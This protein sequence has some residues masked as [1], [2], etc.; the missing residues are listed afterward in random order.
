MD[1]KSSAN[2]VDPSS[3][4]GLRIIVVDPDTASLMHTATILEEHYYTV[5]T[6][7]L[8]T[9]ALSMIRERENQYDLVIAEFNMLEMDGFTFLKHIL[10]DRNIPVILMSHKANVEIIIRALEEGACF[11]WR[12]PL[13][14]KDLINVWQHI[15]RNKVKAKT[16]KVNKEKLTFQEE[17]SFTGK[18]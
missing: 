14:E 11:F 10:R 16:Q 1:V 8:A 12:K 5:T 6:I 18:K 13:R 3:A 15:I 9:I 2:V 17:E 4:R 7:E